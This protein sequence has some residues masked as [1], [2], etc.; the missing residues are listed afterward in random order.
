M[1]VEQGHRSERRTVLF[2]RHGQAY[3]D[4]E[5]YDA[6]EHRPLT[7]AGRQ[8]VAEIAAQIAPFAPQR[9]F[10]SYSLR[11]YQTAYSLGE[12]LGLVP[13][14]V[15]GLHERTFQSLVGLTRI[16]IAQRFG[17]AIADA[18]EHGSDTIELPGEETLLQARQ[19]VHSAFFQVL[20]GAQERL[21]IVSHG[22]PHG[23]L[24]AAELG[25]GETRSRLFRLDEAS[26]S[27]LEF[28]RVGSSFHLQQVLALN[29][30]VLP[31]GLAH[32]GKRL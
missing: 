15:A 32:R 9:L 13:E 3:S 26:F 5:R 23:W 31:P 2:V 7:P 16:Q 21:A 29:T 11:V 27:L 10:C 25:V 19:R 6:D 1:V 12:R 4:P 22:G 14:Q 28:A 18:V 30:R 20:R 24:L 8:A 17:P